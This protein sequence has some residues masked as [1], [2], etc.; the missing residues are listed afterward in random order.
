VTLRARLTLGT[1]VLLA[2]AIVTALS[3]AYLLIQRELNGEIDHALKSRAAS[4]AAL[5]ARLPLTGPKLPTLKRPPRLG[6]AEPEGY[7]QIVSTSGRIILAPGE[8]T[9][10]PVSGALEVAK[11]T[12]NAY[13]FNANVAGSPVR[14]YVAPAE[15]GAVEVARSVADLNTAL[16]RIRTLFTAISLLAIAA[17]TTLAFFVA[18]TTLLPVAKLTADAERIAKTGD[19]REGTDEERRDE[20][21]RLARAF[22]TM[23]R[24]LRNSLSAQR[25]LV[26]D[27]SH[28]LRTP[29]TTARTSL[30]S[31]ERHPELPLRDRQQNVR[32]AITELEEMTR[33]IDELV[34]LARAD[35]QASPRQPIRLDELVGEAV[36]TSRRRTGRDIRLT[37]HPAVVEAAPEDVTRAVANLLDNAVKWSDRSTPIEV[38]VQGGVIS[39]RDHGPGIADADRPHVF[40]RF[41]RATADRTLPGS[42]LGLAIVRQVAEAHGGEATVDAAKG[43]GSL[44]RLA[45]PESRRKQ[46]TEMTVLGVP[47]QENNLW[48]ISRLLRAYAF[49]D[50]A[51]TLETAM[52]KGQ[53]TLTLDALERSALLFVLA[54]I[55]GQFDDLRRALQDALR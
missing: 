55:H 44:F 31:L 29:L 52:T 16:S 51:D 49:D 25:Q 13:F 11:H 22:N 38:T 23:L 15:A 5:N 43:G 9:K 42:G 6:F 14:I 26:A 21:G 1:G 17:T 41:Y 46:P 19:L 54:E 7:V 48:E 4:A 39:V 33:L 40:D 8:T 3:I 2:I 20:L 28:E 18:R 24:A 47:L 34:A 10:L 45:L 37:T 53:E 36:A 27:A 30:E 35:A 50:V 12:R 32:T